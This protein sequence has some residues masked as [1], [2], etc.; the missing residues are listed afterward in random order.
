MELTAAEFMLISIV[1]KLELRAPIGELSRPVVGGR[2]ETQSWTRR[3]TLGFWRRLRV[4][5]EEGLEVM[6]MMGPE[7]GRVV[8]E[9]K[10]CEGR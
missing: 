2:E 9:E 3:E 4:F 6:R 10:G 1:A 5:F 8:V 7:V